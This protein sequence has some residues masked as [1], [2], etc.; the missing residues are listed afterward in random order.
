M[1][2]SRRRF[3]QSGL[4]AGTAVSFPNIHTHLLAQS[5]NQKLNIAVV[6]V[7]NM[8]I[9]A[10]KASAK[11]NIVALCDVDSVVAARPFKWYPNV[12]RF[13]DF[14][15]MLDKMG[16]EIDAVCISTPD[17]THFPIAMA[18]MELG[19][20]VFVQKPLAHNI[21]QVRTL[22]RAMHYY[23]VVTQMGNQ[24]HFFSGMNRIKEWVG[25]GVIGDV[26]RVDTWT[27]R[28]REPW[29]RRP[30]SVPPASHAAPDSLDW[31][32]WLGPAK[33]RDY[34]PEYVPKLWRGWWDFGLGSLGD[35]GCH[36]FDAPFCTLG[37]GMPTKVE[38]DIKEGSEGSDAYIPWGAK[39]TYHFPAR[40]DAPPVVMTWYEDGH[41]VPTPEGWEG[42]FY[43]KGGGMV[44]YGSKETLFHYD[45]R[46]E[47]P[48]FLPK[49]RFDVLKP[50]L[51]E[52]PRIPSVKGPIEQWIRVIK[53]EESE[54]GSN[55]DY[56][57]PLT[58]VVL[59]GALAQRLGKT[60]E[61][62]FER[63]EITNISG[64]DHLIKEPA[65]EGWSYGEK[66]WP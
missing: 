61:Y 17:H 57:G 41:P 4:L 50:E 36:T 58:E 40:G 42:K 22:Q 12:P 56:A 10:V 49:E 20:H 64:L 37:L 63:M 60:I 13:T 48:Q 34:S 24:G 46:P 33:Y 9:Y 45:M 47:S 54:A 23:K 26:T 52:I 62:D 8:G 11:E 38:V 14:R 51:R 31:D 55:F 7:G 19:K 5:P 15:V 32:L 1:N 43:P 66:L 6:G 16:N 30:T 29:F 2:T 59:L 53:G 3:I 28:P 65:R 35:I 25:A 27:N 39:T 21:W 44:M 18:C